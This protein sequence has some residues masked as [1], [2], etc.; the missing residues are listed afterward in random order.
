MKEKGKM[1][2]SVH[3]D[4]THT[5]NRVA[6]FGD[7]DACD[8]LLGS[9]ALAESMA[10]AE[11]CPQ[12]IKEACSIWR[13]MVQAMIAEMCSGCEETANDNPDPLLN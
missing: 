9:L 12:S 11:G 7:I 2:I 6:F 13:V 1:V 5:R 8:T 4:E 10:L 3:E